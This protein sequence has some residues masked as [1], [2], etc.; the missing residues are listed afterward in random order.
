MSFRPT[1]SVYAQGRI[2]DIGY[3]RNWSEKS[4]LYE[5]VAI[6]ALYRDCRT[7]E[8]YRQKRFGTQHVSYIVEPETFENTEEN[9]KWLEECSEW[10]I[11]VDLTAR[12]IYLGI[13]AKSREE[14]EKIPEFDE[15]VI[16]YRQY[17]GKRLEIPGYDL[18]ETG[19]EFADLFDYSKL[20][21]DRMDL[22]EVIRCLKA[23]PE[24]RHYLS[25][26]VVKKLDTEYVGKQ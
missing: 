24:A 3:Y 13:E 19:T 10:P 23:W 26:D 25:A 21:F 15:E 12:C 4:L 14:L 2:A 5:A 20:P 16:G 8:E 17:R 1:I 9:L 22:E 18:F 11:L 6:A 7:V